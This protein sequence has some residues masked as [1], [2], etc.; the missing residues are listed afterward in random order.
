MDSNQF[1]YQDL[2]LQTKESVTKRFNDSLGE[3]KELFHRTGRFDDANTK[4]DEITKLLTIKFFDLRNH[5]NH[6]SVDQLSLLAQRKF[7]D[8]NK[9]AEALQVV[10]KEVAKSDMFANEDGTNIFGANP[11]LNIQ[12][13]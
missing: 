5:T 6:L 2:L 4:L 11:H 7:K 8:K 13:A 3:L 9:I 12:S 10:F 1:M